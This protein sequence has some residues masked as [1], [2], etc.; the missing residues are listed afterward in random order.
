M[1][2]ILKNFQKK[3]LETKRIYYLCAVFLC[4]EHKDIIETTKRYA[5]LADGNVRNF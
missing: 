1:K 5:R 2:A 4:R 3:E